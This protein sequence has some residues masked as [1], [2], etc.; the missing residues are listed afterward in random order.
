MRRTFS[1]RL[2][3]DKYELG[4]VSKELRNIGYPS[5]ENDLRNLSTVCPKLWSALNLSLRDIDY[6]IRLLAFLMRTSSTGSYVFYELL[7]LLIGLKFKNPGLYSSLI[8][9][10]FLTRDIVEYLVLESG[11]KL[12]ARDF[13]SHFDQIEGFLYCVD[14]SNWSPAPA[15]SVALVELKQVPEQGSGY[16]YEVISQRAQDAS[17]EII[18]RISRS[19]ELARQVGINARVFGVL[20]G[21]IDTYQMDVRR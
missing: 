21:L 6:G 8:L 10:D 12:T 2:V 18:R 1:T 5:F 11:S 3:I 14:K 7:A 20:A 17:I 13:I 4:K 19:I 9:G 15:G 16:T